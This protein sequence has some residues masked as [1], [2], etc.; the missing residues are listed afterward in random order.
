[1]AHYEIKD[2]GERQRFDTGATRDTQEGKGRFDLISPDV[3]ERLALHFEGGVQKYGERNWEKGIPLGRYID[4]ALRHVNKW[5]QGERDEDHLT[6]AIWNL[7]CLVQTVEW[8][9]EGRLPWSLDDNHYLNTEL[10]ALVKETIPNVAEMAGSVEQAD[11]DDICLKLH[12]TELPDQG[13]D[14]EKAPAGI[15]MLHPHEGEHESSRQFGLKKAIKYLMDRG[16]MRAADFYTVLEKAGYSLREIFGARHE[17]GTEII[18][19]SVSPM[20]NEKHS[21]YNV[22]Q[23]KE[24]EN[25]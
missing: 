1:M 22:I 5:R 6:A 10:T 23:Y 21:G 2:S 9:K 18:H 25:Q 20:Y 3:Q 17:V 16:P 7:H 11:H 15:Y 19:V 13:P 24:E 12:Y 4:S 14:P 8:I